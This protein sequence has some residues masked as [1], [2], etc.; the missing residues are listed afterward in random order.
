MKRRMII[1]AALLG[2]VAIAGFLWRSRRTPEAGEEA[3]AGERAVT[4]WSRLSQVREPVATLRYGERVAVLDHKKEQTQLRTASG[5]VGWTEQRNLMDAAL[6][7]RAA[8][9]RAHARELPVQAHAHT[10][11]PTNVRIEPGRPAARIFQLPGTVRL[12][13]LERAVVEVKQ[14]GEEPS[15]AGSANSPPANSPSANTS[16]D[17]EV[18]KEDWVLVRGTVEDAG[19]VAGWVLRRFID[20]DT[21]Q[22][23]ADYAAGF[24]FVAWFE[25]NS[26]A[27]GDNKRPQYVAAGV[28]GGD[29]QPC[30]FTL[31]RVYTWGTERHRY[32]TA[33]VES[34]LCGHFPIRAVP[35]RATGGD[36]GFSFT[37]NG[38]RGQESREYE[39]HLTSVHRVDLEK[40]RRAAARRSKPRS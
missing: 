25:L 13:I 16:G 37:N 31:L 33:Y 5:A 36:A 35:A 32:E 12:E 11:V 20:L 14:G 38:R 23:I 30:D 1:G 39:M 9:I 34:F 40:R 19:E 4:V 28:Q 6:W 21:P 17:Q 27:D 18:K 3:Y 29:G 22:E 8:Q 24:R 7:N 15:A 10:R 2:A 26:V